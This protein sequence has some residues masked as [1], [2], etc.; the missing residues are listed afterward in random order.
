MYVATSYAWWSLVLSHKHW[1]RIA[2]KPRWS[3]CDWWPKLPLHAAK[4]SCSHLSRENP[5]WH[6][7]LGM[8]HPINT[9]KTI[10]IRKYMVHCIRITKTSNKKSILFVVQN[11][12]EKHL[13]GADCRIS[14]HC[15]VM[16]PYKSWRYS[17]SVRI[18]RW[19]CHEKDK[20]DANG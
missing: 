4:W 18:V 20:S 9:E 10:V 12:C 8:W 6:L 3:I 19:T 11:H 17:C 2:G 13:R 7:A 15:L 16:G 1:I 14:L 5:V